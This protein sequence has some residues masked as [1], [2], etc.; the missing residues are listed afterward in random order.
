MKVCPVKAITRDGNGACVINYDKCIGCKM[1][2]NACPLGNMSYSTRL[3]RVFKCDL[4]GG[5][6]KCVRFCPGG[7]LLFEDPDQM[8]QRKRQTADKIVAAMGTEG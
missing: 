5:E 1:C 6:P 3:R 7:A 2:K 4:C 8:D